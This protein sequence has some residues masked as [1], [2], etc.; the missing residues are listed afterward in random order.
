MAGPL[1]GLKVVEMVG[2]GP[3]PFAAMLLADMG[4]EVI[5]IDRPQEA[6]KG[7]R[8]VPME[9]RF[10][11]LA[12]GRRSLA[13]D[14]RKPGAAEIVLALMAQADAVIEGF[15]PGV[16]ERLGLAPER[17]LERN[18]KLVFGRMTGWGQTGP[19][20]HAA[21]H[22]IHYL[23]AGPATTSTTSRWPGHCMRSGPRAKHPCRRS[24]WWGISG[25]AACSWPSA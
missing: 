5:R 6:G 2:I 18:P 19:L 17:C 9:P 25:A 16:M 20:A 8:G 14:L 23:L 11:V 3:G 24:T 22:D 13:I 15:R 10:D 7:A 12:R 4:A 21:G 1:E